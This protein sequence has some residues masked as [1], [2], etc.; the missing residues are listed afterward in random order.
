M[1]TG[2][3]GGRVVGLSGLQI[4]LGLLWGGSPGGVGGML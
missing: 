1:R 2:R 4:G 3:P